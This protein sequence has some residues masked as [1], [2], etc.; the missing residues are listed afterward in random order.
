MKISMICFSL[1]GLAVMERLK[2]A[3][4]EEHHQ[5]CAAAKGKYLPDS[6]EGTVKDWCR[7]Q[8]AEADALVFVS[9][10]GI[11]VRAVAPWIRSKKTDPAVVVVDERG[12]FSISLLSGHLGG[13]NALAKRCGEILGA[14][15]VITTAT[16]LNGLFAVDVFASHQGMELRNMKAAKEVSAAL[17]AGKN[18]GFYSEFPV[19]GE[20]P[21]GILPCDASGRPL[22]G[23]SKAPLPVGF[24]VT[25]YRNASPFSSTAVLI[26]KKVTLGL[27]C[28]RGKEVSA[29]EA[30]AEEALEKC[31]IY[32]ESIKCVASIDLKAEEEGI[33][34]FC[35]KRELPFYTYSAKKL[36]EVP[37]NFTGSDF[38]L[39]KTGVDN[40]CER[41][42][43]RA[44]GGRLLLKKIKGDGVTAALA[45]EEWSVEF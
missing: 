37:G 9:A 30:A 41:S 34:E 22:E 42:A 29:I 17:L 23:A 14:V 38:V 18:V 3:L 20:F 19:K 12:S 21:R 8:F 28:R 1:T 33:I 26:P 16:D 31:G 25:I 15:P 43:L 36:M 32:P 10:S 2:K 40:V 7:I 13:A 44:G 5:V 24:A 11:A 6:M 45:L 35:K 4:E 39:E 27:G